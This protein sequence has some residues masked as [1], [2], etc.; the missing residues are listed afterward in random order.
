MIQSTTRP[1]TR[2]FASGISSITQIGPLSDLIAM[3]DTKCFSKNDSS[4]ST[5]MK[6]SR[7]ANKISFDWYDF[8][9]RKSEA[10]RPMVVT[11]YTRIDWKGE[12]LRVGTEREIST[13][14]I[15]VPF[16]KEKLFLFRSI[17]LHVPLT[18]TLFAWVEDHKKLYV[19]PLVIRKSIRDLD[20]FVQNNIEYNSVYNPYGSGAYHHWPEYTIHFMLGWSSSPTSQTPWTFAHKFQLRD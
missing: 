2:T 5:T 15:Q 11:L 9:Y 19:M 17:E 6:K 3:K 4:E 18:V 14:A 7:H 20:S 8:E 12:T 16:R 13:W 1:P 10:M